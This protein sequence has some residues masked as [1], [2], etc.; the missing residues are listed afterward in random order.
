VVDPPCM[1]PV[2][3]YRTSVEN[4]KVCIET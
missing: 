3:T 1:I 2:K 4:G